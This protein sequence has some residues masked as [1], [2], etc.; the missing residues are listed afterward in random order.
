MPVDGPLLPLIVFE[1]LF[2]SAFLCGFAFALLSG[3]GE[4]GK[5]TE[6]PSGFLL[7]IDLIFPV[8]LLRDLGRGLHAL[9]SGKLRIRQRWCE[10]SLARVCFWGFAI[11]F[12]TFVVTLRLPLG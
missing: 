10:R 12:T 3:N 7:L 8:I 1:G 5:M 6:P 11:C 2:A 4:P 9:V